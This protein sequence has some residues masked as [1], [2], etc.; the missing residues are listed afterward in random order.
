MILLDGKKT[1]EIIKNNIKKQVE[2]FVKKGLRPPHLT[3]ILV[4]NDP[5]SV[6]YVKNKEKQSKKVGFTS[7]LIHL[8]ADTSEADLLNIIMQLN[9]DD[10]VDGYIVQLPLPKHIN[11]HKIINAIDPNKDVDGFHPLNLGQ[12][13]AQLPGFIP[14]TPYGIVELIKYYNIPT[15]GQNV[16]IIGRS[17]I[18]GRPLSILL[19]QKRPNGNATVTLAHSH[20]KNLK[21]LSRQADIIVTALGKPNFLT[22]DMVKDGVVII[23][24]GINEVPD[25]QSKRG[26]KL[27]GDVAFDEVSKKA[28]YITPVPGGVGPMTITMLLKN[29]L[30]AYKMKHL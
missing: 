13:L 8:P 4:G 27:V 1:A 7:S 3:A 16:L 23:D 25:K 18:V 2:G 29:T 11:P 15:D 26:F 30:E 28:S 20:T 5:A 17:L 14:A 19:S 10:Q 9:K 12:L 21:T 24:A 22:A 6:A